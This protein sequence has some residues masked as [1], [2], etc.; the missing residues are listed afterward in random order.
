MRQAMKSENGQHFD[1]QSYI[2]TDIAQMRAD[3]ERPPRSA[4][5]VVD[6]EIGPPYAG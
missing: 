5:L 2:G 4:K 1:V 6:L 3:G